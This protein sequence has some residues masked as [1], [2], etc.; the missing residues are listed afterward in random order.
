[1]NRIKKGDQVI[2]IRGKDKGREGKVLEVLPHKNLL[3]VEGV[4]LIHKCRKPNPKQN[5]KGGI[6]KKEALINA[7]SAM[8]LNPVTH[9]AD[10]IGVKTLEDGQK[11]RY[12]K[13]NKEVV[14]I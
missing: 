10:R 14:D 5:L 13:S 2:V 7:S 11:V 1:M 12:F 3:R 4:N 8:L 9:K 6:F